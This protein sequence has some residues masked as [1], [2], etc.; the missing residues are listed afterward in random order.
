MPL[1]P[2][3][4]PDYVERGGGLVYRPPYTARKVALDGFVVKADRSA[5]D[6]LVQNDLVEPTA[7]AVSFQAV[8]DHVIVAFTQIGELASGDPVDRQ[9]G[10]MTEL[11]VSVWCLL[12]DVHAGDR[13]CWY[14]PYV[15]TDS[16]QTMATGREVYG[17][18]KQTG[19]FAGGPPLDLAPG[20]R[21]E[22]EALAIDPFDPQSVATSRPMVAVQR[23][24]SGTGALP[25]LG[26]VSS[27]L[28]EV[29][30]LFPGSFSISATVA[31]GSPPAADLQ[32]TH[33]GQS[34]AKKPAAP[35]PVKQVLSTMG[36]GG[37]VA[38]KP[39]LVASLVADPRLVFL[40]QFRDVAC[41]TK[42]CYQ[43]IIEAPLQLHLAG[44]SYHAYDATELTMEIAD[45]ASHPIAGDLGVAGAT[46]LPVE[47][48]FRAEF[49]FDTLLG[50]ERWRRP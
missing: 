24:A 8:H 44:A 23:S 32:I 12:A 46:P 30:E 36:A 50:E 4:L 33:P 37:L 34:P 21:A 20:G 18:P 19:S 9:R 29:D 48:A 17:Y 47:R 25:S 40:K 3:H 43:S 22:V 5:I 16:A 26:P 11:E 1:V 41:P 31:S 15:F 28:G 38:D 42:A 35:W 2:H 45:W 14:L 39:A 10:F 27:L 49:G 7:G 13:L 6:A